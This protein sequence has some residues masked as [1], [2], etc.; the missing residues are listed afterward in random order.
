[1]N[2]ETID[3]KRHTLIWL[4]D[5]ARQ[6]AADHITSQSW[7]DPKCHRTALLMKTL[8]CNHAIPGIICR[9]PTD[10][11]TNR[12]HTITLAG[13]SHWIQEGGCR[14]RAAAEFPAKAIWKSC[15]PFDLC[16][17]GHRDQLCS[18]YPLLEAI[19]SAADRYHIKPGLFGSTALEWITG[20]PYRNQNSDLDLCLKPM[21]G[22]DLESF[23]HILSQLETQYN[24]RLDAEVEVAEGYGVKLKELLS[25]TKTVLGKGLYDVTLF[26]RKTVFDNLLL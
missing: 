17:P 3:L 23:G 4:T 1:M 14:L 9:Q 7:P 22:C 8:I 13:F 19:F 21:P 6:Y 24:T 15:T 2:Q 25:A 5:S 18:A 26:E 12:F 11:E 10:D 20:Y 16:E